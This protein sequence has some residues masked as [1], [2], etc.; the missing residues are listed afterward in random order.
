MFINIKIAIN[1]QL[2]QIKILKNQFSN[3]TNLNTSISLP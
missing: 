2:M 3:N 1:L